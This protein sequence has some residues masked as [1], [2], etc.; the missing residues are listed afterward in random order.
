VGCG[1]HPHHYSWHSACNKPCIPQAWQCTLCRTRQLPS[2]PQ[3]P[4]HFGHKG[5]KLN[6]KCQKSTNLG[7]TFPLDPREHMRV[8]VLRCVIKHFFPNVLENYHKRKV[9][10]HHQRPIT[11]VFYVC[12]YVCMYVC[13][14]F[15]YG[16]LMMDSKTII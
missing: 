16:L 4:M 1:R 10:R 5:T 6:L 15:M 2:V 14:L 13:N 3:S 12:M 8:N 9:V 11:Y 7:N